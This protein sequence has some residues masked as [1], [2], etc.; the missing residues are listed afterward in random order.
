M[1]DIVIM[2]LIVSLLYGISPILYKYIFL[3]YQYEIH[4]FTLLLISSFVFFVCTLFCYIVQRDRVKQDF[5]NLY[6]NKKVFIILISSSLFSVFIA[7]LLYFIILKK[8]N[9]KS[10]I[11]S[12]L[13][14]TS[15]LFTLL[16]SYFFLNE[17]IT[18]ITLL[19]I[20]LIVTGILA[21]TL[22]NV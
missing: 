16:L 17:G 2:S 4:T 19:S 3:I 12:T 1:W 5:I 7:N 11:V 15:P 6:K 18:I 10:Y 20:V 21:L 22:T 9:T 13:V 14:F 8:A